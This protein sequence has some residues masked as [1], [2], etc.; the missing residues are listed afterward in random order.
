[1]N[2]QWDLIPEALG[3]VRV[4]CANCGLEAQVINNM[5]GRAIVVAECPAGFSTELVSAPVL[6]QLS[7]EE[8][9]NPAHVVSVWHRAKDLATSADDPRVVI[10]TTNGTHVIRDR[11]LAEVA[12]LINGGQA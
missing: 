8:W 9:V 1:M 7:G 5:I 10:F 6:V 11:S 3:D 2:H 12:A 4:V